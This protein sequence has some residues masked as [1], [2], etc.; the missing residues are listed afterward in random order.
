MCVCVF[1]CVCVCVCV[2][3]IYM[4]PGTRYFFPVISLA[5]R[6]PTESNGIVPATVAISRH[7]HSSI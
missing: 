6:V 2:C 4:Y 5:V 1:V 3:V 7:G